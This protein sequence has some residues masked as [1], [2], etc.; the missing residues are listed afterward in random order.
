MA[1][2]QEEHEGCADGEMATLTNRI[3]LVEPSHCAYIV[4]K[5]KI[6]RIKRDNVC[7]VPGTESR[8]D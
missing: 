6:R 5:K 1:P 8:F 7:G 3:R 4:I 2:S